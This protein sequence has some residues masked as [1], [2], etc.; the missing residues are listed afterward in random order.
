MPHAS[1]RRL[2]VLRRGP[3]GG[4]W[5]WAAGS[6]LCQPSGR[7]WHQRRFTGAWHV[8]CGCCGVARRLLQLP[9]C[10]LGVEH[11]ARRMLCFCK[12]GNEAGTGGTLG[13]Q[14]Q[15]ASPLHA[16]ICCCRFLLAS[17]R[18]ATC[19]ATQVHGRRAPRGGG[20]PAAA[21]RRRPHADGDGCATGARCIASPRVAVPPSLL[22]T[23]PHPCRSLLL[24]AGRLAPGACASERRRR[25]GGQ[26]GTGVCGGRPQ[27]W[28]HRRR[29]P[30]V[31][32]SECSGAGGP[33][34]GLTP[35]PLL[36]KKCFLSA[37]GLCLPPV[38][39]ALHYCSEAPGCSFPARLPPALPCS[40]AS[41]AIALRWHGRP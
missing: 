9:L 28:R 39:C 8:C 30:Q 25:L 22:V 1:V 29:P 13:I 27:V 41:A 10:M 38:R 19:K 11:G 7:A 34:L 6:I 31:L 40:A 21:D 18:C 5:Q 24:P 36:P 33:V 17:T 23:T 14:M 32:G 12:A 15:R 20:R 16:V 4:G 35:L 2:A 3:A 37:S 26:L